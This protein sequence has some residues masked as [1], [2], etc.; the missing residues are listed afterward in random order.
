[1]NSHFAA[2]GQAYREENVTFDEDVSPN[3]YDGLYI[4]ASGTVEYVPAG[5][6]VSVVKPLDKGWHPVCIKEVKAAGT[7]LTENQ[8]WG[9]RSYKA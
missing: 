1:M 5:Q 8:I 3:F 4:S 2:G 9:T 6:D 7:T